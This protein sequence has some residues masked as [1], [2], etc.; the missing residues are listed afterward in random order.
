MS[1]KLKVCGAVLGFWG[2]S[3]GLLG[4][5]QIAIETGKQILPNAGGLILPNTP[6][7]DAIGSN[8]LTVLLS[9]RDDGDGGSKPVVEVVSTLNIEELKR[10]DND[11]DPAKVALLLVFDQQE[12]SRILGMLGENGS[13]PDFFKYS[14]TFKPIGHYNVGPDKNVQA[15]EQLTFKA[16]WANLLVHE[17]KRVA[18]FRGAVKGAI[19]QF[20]VPFCPGPSPRLSVH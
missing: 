12:H 19:A 20:T 10:L 17:N 4:C 8:R 2:L 1:E 11:N 6:I 7:P 15:G 9:C 14:E 18:R 3:W 13:N 5:G 16:Y